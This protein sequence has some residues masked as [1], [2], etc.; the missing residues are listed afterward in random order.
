[1]K[2][3]QPGLGAS[4]LLISNSAAKVNGREMHR[5]RRGP[6]SLGAPHSTYR[7]IACGGVLHP[8]SMRAGKI[9]HRGTAE[10]ASKKVTLGRL[11]RG[12][13]QQKGWTLRQMSAK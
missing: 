4:K 12:L 10:M 1:M 7:N 3:I 6:F 8:A 9:S 5:G 2:H 11:I 13:R